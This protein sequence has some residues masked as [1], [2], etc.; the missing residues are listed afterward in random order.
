M[1]WVMF[2]AMFWVAFLIVLLFRSVVFFSCFGS[3][4][5]II[6]SLSFHSLTQR[7]HLPP[8][9]LFY[10]HSPSSGKNCYCLQR[11]KLRLVL[12]F[13]TFLGQDVPC[14]FPE[15]VSAKKGIFN[16]LV[17]LLLEQMFVTLVMFYKDTSFVGSAPFKLNYLRASLLKN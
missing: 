2:W 10:K 13:F 15:D 12:L 3:Y 11:S 9:N 16:I 5:Q 14:F 4:P 7:L 8:K 17:I 6:S 1:F